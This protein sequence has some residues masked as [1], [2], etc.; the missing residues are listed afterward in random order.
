MRR[1]E[2]AYW[3]IQYA[4]FNYCSLLNFSANT[5]TMLQTYVQSQQ[6]AKESHEQTFKPLK[7]KKGG[8]EHTSKV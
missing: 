3:N 4:T 7:T 5:K 2:S 8:H 1:G 6:N